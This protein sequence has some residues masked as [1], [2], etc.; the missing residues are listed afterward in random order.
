MAL[1]TPDL[2]LGVSGGGTGA[3]TAFLYRVLM[4]S[5]RYR[6]DV[7]SLATSSLDS[8]SVCIRK[9]N[10]WFQG[11]R[12]REARWRDVP[13]CHVGAFLSE[14]EFQRYRPRPL[15]ND[16]F[17]KYDLIQFVVGFPC[18]V[19]VACE[20]DTPVVLWTATTLMP[21]RINRLHEIRGPRGL[22]FKAMTRISSRYEDRAIR[23]AHTVFALSSYTFNLIKGKDPS[24]NLHMATCGIDTEF[25]RPSPK[26]EQG[27]GYILSVGRFSDPRKNVELL[28]EA[29]VLLAD[30]RVSIPDLYL[31]GDPPLNEWF[32]DGLMKGI[33]EKIRFL[34]PK[35]GEELAS[36]YREASFFVL[37]SDEEGLGIVVLEAMS[38]GLPIVSTSCGGPESL[39]A[40]GEN[41]FLVPIR[42]P[43]A[44]VGA[45]DKLL[46]DS[47][48]R[49]RMGRA[50]RKAA[51][52][53]FSMNVAG[54][55][56]LKKFDEIIDGAI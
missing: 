12:T 30:R 43:G 9:P 15:L 27:K 23:K 51:E 36:L 38:S 24:A 32:S 21:D 5:G 54:E 1:V 49:G 42:D 18:W 13:F 35:Q 41:G 39:V 56:F 2:A 22:W 20:V 53:R 6:P 3:M 25:Y 37:P 50:G 26:E 44:M 11:P 33:R 28:L 14:F 40:D 16:I 10:T 19:C 52:E 55:I 7:I 8:T 48:L 47:E 31:V 45:M 46:D 17:R 29:Y 4:D 34:G